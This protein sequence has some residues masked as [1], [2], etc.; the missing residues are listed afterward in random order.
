M[1]VTEREERI[2]VSEWMQ[3]KELTDDVLSDNRLLTLPRK[4]Y[5]RYE[6]TPLC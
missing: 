4:N 2:L 1:I 3:H 5:I 6:R